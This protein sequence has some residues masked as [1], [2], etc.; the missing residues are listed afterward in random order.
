MQTRKE[1]KDMHAALITNRATTMLIAL[2]ASIALA[3][4][5]APMLTGAGARSEPSM[6]ANGCPPHC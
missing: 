5:L 6:P 2:L 3:T 1:V 4:A